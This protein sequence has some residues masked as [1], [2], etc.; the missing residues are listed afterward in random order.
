MNAE[1]TPQ[2]SRSYVARSTPTRPAAVSRSPERTLRAV[3]SSTG[4]VV[5]ALEDGT[6]YTVAVEV[7]SA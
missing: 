3:V 1:A 6:R 5:V 7:M 4:R 2:Y